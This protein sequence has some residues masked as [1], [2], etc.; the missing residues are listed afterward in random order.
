MNGEIPVSSHHDSYAANLRSIQDAAIRLEG[1]AHKTPVM[2]SDTMDRLTGKKLFFKCENF[3]R[4]GAFKF[5]GAMNALTKHME[6]Q[7]PK[8]VVTHSSGNHAQAVAL[9]AKIHGLPAHIV[10]PTDAPAVKRAAVEGYGATIHPCAPV[11]EARE[12]TAARVVEETGGL[13]IP[14]Y[15]HP[16]VIAGQG[17]VGLEMYEQIGPLDAIIVPVGGGGLLSG[18]T[19]AY[20]ELSPKTVIYAAEPSGADDAY[21][22]KQAGAWIPQTSPNTIADG[23]RTS[24]GDWTWP[25]VRDLVHEVIRVDDPAIVHAMK[26]IWE[27]MK[28]VIEPSSAIGLAALLCGAIQVPETQNRL[29]IV[30]G[31]GNLDLSRLPWRE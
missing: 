21:R 20:N 4:V 22:S 16:D 12:S 1:H 27:R 28:L 10:M 11:L 18:I 13:L 23:L 8:A 9:A 24:L 26:L 19:L 15:D 17:T 2:T 3:Q 31:G 5:R 7:P 30:I 25:V 14:P 6:T 29:G